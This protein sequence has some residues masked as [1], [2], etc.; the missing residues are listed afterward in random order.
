MRMT[1]E[2]DRSKHKA[3]SVSCRME[4]TRANF[5]QLQA[6]AANKD[7]L[8]ITIV[9]LLLSQIEETHGKNSKASDAVDRE[10]QERPSSYFVQK[11]RQTTV[12]PSKLRGC[13]LMGSKGGTLDF[14]LEL[15]CSYIEAE[16]R[17]RRSDNYHSEENFNDTMQ[18]DSLKVS[19]AIFTLPER[20]IIV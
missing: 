14:N 4:E 20:I 1:V 5:H 9:D 18:E 10:R 13:G 15:L 8:I 11:L 17:R 3:E 2:L 16:G 7:F 19:Y 12:K 6:K